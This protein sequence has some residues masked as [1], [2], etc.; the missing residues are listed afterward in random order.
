LSNRFKTIS[1]G[2]L[3][4]VYGSV[5]GGLA[6]WRQYAAYSN[7]HAF[8]KD[9][10]RCSGCHLESKPEKGRPYQVMNFRRDI[11]SLCEQCHMLK[12][13]HPVDVAP[14]RMTGNKLPLDAD[15]TM[16]CVTCHAPH[17][18]PFSNRMFTGRT[19][20]EKV[21]DT[22]FPMLPGRFRTHFLRMATP[23]GELCE[24]CHAGRSIATRRGEIKPTDPA[25]YAGSKS[26]EKC[27][28]SEYA[29]WG[30][31][32]HARMLR[33]PRKDPGALVAVFGATPPFPPSEIAYVLG[34]RNVQR[35]ISRRGDSMVVRTPIWL[36]R[37]KKWNLSYWREL[38]WIRLCSGCHTTGMDPTQAAFAEEGIGCE[39]CHGPGRKH[40]ASTAKSDIV[41][42]RRLP[43]D[44]RDMICEACHTAGHDSTGEFRFP[45]GFVPGADLTRHFFGLTPKPGQDDL[46][47]KG[48]GSY[49]DRHRQF[50]FWQTQ[51]LIVEGETCD[52]CKNFREARKETTGTG[53][54]KMTPEE[55][56]VSCHD[57][58]I[59]TLARYHD[60]PEVASRRC[61]VCHP[62][63]RNAAGEVSI[64]DHRF[65]PD[66]AL[67]KN[68]FIPSPDFRSICFRCHPVPQSKGV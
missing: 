39:A 47:F 48:D 59:V 13:T 27:H 43:P 56:C 55:Y 52:L 63:V 14:G 29:Q 1:I 8:M 9:P 17:S 5:Y 44:R 45:A 24:R 6:L 37:A 49:E 41:N 11:Y 62:P 54:Q 28:P 32:A 66:S 31:T 26:C 53:P 57:G 21:R 22:L 50:L 38:D 33:S 65:L 23:R 16:T 42:P 51:M 60:H 19:T 18:A 64:H 61:Q 2:I 46:S 34:S 58:T 4:L 25:T 7:P 40:A 36:I 30:K 35:F 67:Q 3:I 68:D 20:W 15:G 12:V 10:A